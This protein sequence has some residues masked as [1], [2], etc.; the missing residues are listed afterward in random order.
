MQA[1]VQTGFLNKL[2]Y[3]QKDQI[4]GK[5]TNSSYSM[6]LPPNWYKKRIKSK[7]I[8]AGG[9]QTVYKAG[10]E[11]WRV[12][13]LSNAKASKVILKSYNEGG[14]LVRFDENGVKYKAEN[15]TF[16]YSMRTLKFS[17]SFRIQTTKNGRKHARS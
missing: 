15:V 11:C 3:R 8:A 13:K 14:R 7:L 6:T 5:G 10:F 16:R 17:T 4:H 9:K 12:E 1:F 2:N